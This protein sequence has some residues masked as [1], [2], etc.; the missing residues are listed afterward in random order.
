MLPL[1]PQDPAFM[2][3]HREA[4]ERAAELG[5]KLG[6]PEETVNQVLAEVDQ[7]GRLADLA[8]GYIDIP[9]AERQALLETLAV[10][11]RLPRVPVHVQREVDVISAQEDIQ[12]NVEEEVGG[13]QREMY[14]REH[15]K[16]IQK[17][18]C[19]GEGADND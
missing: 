8:A 15:R 3:L 17:Y 16:S 4:R 10:E 12:E 18:L 9:P 11:D 14:L 6:L 1:D 7:P 2:A 5:K 13:R 19:E